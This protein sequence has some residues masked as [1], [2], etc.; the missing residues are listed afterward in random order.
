MTVGSLSL[1]ITSR[2]T[3]IHG[4]RFGPA[5]SA[6]RS[7]SPDDS[8]SVLHRKLFERARQKT[9]AAALARLD[10]AAADFEG[11]ANG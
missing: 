11:G 7:P 5:C 3:L 8:L 6:K 4:H 2:L 1:A 10:A 9:L